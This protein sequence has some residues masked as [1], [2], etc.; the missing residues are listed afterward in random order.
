VLP[1]WRM[2][3]FSC[4]P[5]QLGHREWAVYMPRGAGGAPAP[6]NSPG[7]LLSYE[8]VVQQT[9]AFNLTALVGNLGPILRPGRS[10]TH[11]P[12]YWLSSR[13]SR[14]SA[15]GFAFV[16]LDT[17]E[18]AGMV[19]V[20]SRP[21]G[22]MAHGR[23]I[24]CSWGKDR[25]DDGTAQPGGPSSMFRP[26]LAFLNLL[27]GWYVG[28]SDQTNS[29]YNLPCLKQCMVCHSPISTGSIWICWWVPRLP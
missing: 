11:P 27:V 5:C 3:W 8:T 14:A 24:K 9:L 26:R 17:H 21:E 29:S 18:N 20:Q 22:Q 4:N 1:Q 2:G 19:I 23:P 16:Q 10:H 25:A 12:L 7:G 15:R 28:C 13:G 6:I